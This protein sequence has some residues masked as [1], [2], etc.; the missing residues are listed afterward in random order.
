M[1]IIVIASLA[2]SLIGFREEM[3]KAFKRAGLD[4]VGLA[5]D[6][7]RDVAEK[8]ES[9]GMRFRTYT[10]SR[11]GMNPINEIRSIRELQAIITEE[12][13]DCVMA[14]TMKPVMYGSI[15]ARRA[16]VKNIY[17]MI[18]GL[19]YAFGDEGGG[20]KRKLVSFIVSNL[21]KSALSANQVV[22]FQ[23]PDDLNYFVNHNLVKREQTRLIN[24]SGVDLTMFPTTPVKPGKP[25]FLMIAR[26]ILEKGVRQF[27]D[28]ARIIKGKHPQAEF[29]LVGPLDPNPLAIQ[30]DEVEQWKQEGIINY[31]GATKDVRPFL[32]EASI[33]VLPTYYREG[34]PRSILEAMSMGRPIITTD[35]PG[36]RETVDHGVN[37]YLVQ[38][39]DV[40]T[41]VESMEYFITHPEQI[42]EMGQ[43]S[44]QMAE[45]KYDVHKVNQTILEPMGLVFH[46]P[47]HASKGDQV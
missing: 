23:N 44:R 47:E 7:N 21:A 29:T 43:A 33:Y 8:L 45:E 28:A 14:Y 20:L 40:D 25:H 2:Q 3:L 41:L 26:L 10:M 15:A 13:A 12:Q 37:G 19:G 11:A 31:P 5:P 18:T 46:P 9:W 35:S 24:G 6:D 32:K 17:S 4:V 36:A 30:A 16:G 38:P 39:R 22:F 42:A 27:V 34:T 1:K